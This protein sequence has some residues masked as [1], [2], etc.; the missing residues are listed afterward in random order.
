MM[1]AAFLRCAPDLPAWAW[2]VGATA[3]LRG[4]SG[5]AR[6]TSEEA[7]AAV[8]RRGRGSAYECGCGAWH[9]SGSGGLAGPSI[10]RWRG[11][12]E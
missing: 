6:Q 8:A 7:T 10:T 2:D 12:A 11:R 3:W 5:K 9:T 1:A 4:C